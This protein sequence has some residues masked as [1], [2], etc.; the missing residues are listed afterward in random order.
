MTDTVYTSD[1]K[2]V[3]ELLVATNYEGLAIWHSYQHQ[4]SRIE[5]LKAQVKYL[6]DYAEYK[7]IKEELRVYNKL[8]KWQWKG[9][10]PKD[11]HWAPILTEDHKEAGK[12]K[13]AMEYN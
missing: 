8:Q 10:E 5:Q 2:S 11:Y 4:V 6:K 9:L 7:G 12:A 3:K 1:P 13:W